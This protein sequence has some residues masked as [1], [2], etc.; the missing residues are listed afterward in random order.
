MRADFAMISGPVEDQ[1]QRLK[2]SHSDLPF[3]R[4]QTF[5]ISK[6]QIAFAINRENQ[7]HKI[8]DDNMRDILLGKIS[9]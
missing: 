2:L 3:K 1:V 5:N 7:V 9:N 8:T 4:L 6:T